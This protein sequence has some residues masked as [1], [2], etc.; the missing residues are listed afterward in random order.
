MRK[1][2]RH[3]SSDPLALTGLV[4]VFVTVTAGIFCKQLAPHD[5]YDVNLADRFT[6][7]SATYPLGTDAMGRDML[8]R[9][10]YGIRISFMTGMIVLAISVPVGVAL[11]TIAGYTSQIIDNFI[12]RVADMFLAFP[13]YI[14]AM[15]IAA[16]LGASLAHAM[17]A[18]ATIWWPNY[19][20]LVRGRV[21][22]IR[23]EDYVLAARAIGVPRWGIM[24]R[25]I[26]PNCLSSILV[27]FSL[28]VGWTILAT[29]SLSFIGMGA[30]PPKP[31]LG[32]MIAHGRIYLLDYPWITIVPGLV[33]FSLLLGVNLL[34]DSIRDLLDPRLRRAR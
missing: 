34:G 10:L 24:L 31:E 1:A 12:M 30:Q 22:S 7:P 27:L 2:I 33:I 21:L 28:D 3:F 20:R 19:T 25:H 5:P 23:E 11:G 15:A 8:S 29:A 26:L 9:V 32:S 4:I 6:P 16:S 17:L 14:L 18:M 13:T